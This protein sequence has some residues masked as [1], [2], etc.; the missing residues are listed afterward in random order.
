[1]KIKVIS[2]FTVLLFLFTCFNVLALEKNNSVSFQTL[3]CDD[4]F[5]FSQASF[6]KTDDFTK[7]S[8][9]EAITYTMDTGKPMLPVVIKTYVFPKGTKI[10][11][12]ECTFSGFSEQKI[13]EKI[14]PAPKKIPLIELNN[15][16]LQQDSQPVLDSSIYQSSDF[17][18]SK[19]YDYSITC[20]ING[21]TL[22]I[23]MYPVKVNSL[24]NILQTYESADIN[25]VYEKPLFAPTYDEEYDMVIIA[26][27]Y[28]VET[29]G[30]LITHKNSIGVKT[31]IKTTEEIYKNYTGVDKPEQIKYFIKDAIE[32]NNIKYVLL[33]GGRINQRLKW[34]VPVRYA[35]VP[36]NFEY[37]FISDLYYADM[38]RYNTTS[39]LTEFDDWDSDMDGLY[40]EYITNGSDIDLVPDVYVGRLACRD[41][42]E[43]GI[44][45]KKIIDYENN[46][47]GSDWFKKIILVGGD[48]FPVI[49]S[50]W[51]DYGSYEGENSTDYAS[52]P[53]KNL[54]FDIVELW[55]STNNLKDSSDVI[56]AFGQGAGFIY[57]DGHGNPSQ[58]ATH[59]PNSESWII[60]LDA[61]EM[62]FLSNSDKY[63]VCIIGGC[64]NSQFD[65]ARGNFIKGLLTE[66]LK[67]FVGL[68]DS[69]KIDCDQGSFWKGEWVTDCWS[70]SL[71]KQ[72]NGGSIATIGNTG[73]GY[74]YI[75]S[76]N[77]N[78]LSSWL[79]SRFFYVYSD[80]V[81]Q[82]N[83][84]VGQ[85]YSQSVTDYIHTFRNPPN[86]ENM[87]W[88]YQTQKTLIGY[89]L[90]GDPSLKIGG[91]S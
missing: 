82:G 43:L 90:L 14:M 30:P 79:T 18:P 47:Y 89:A 1:M 56:D 36:D 6:E 53:M 63:P 45:V 76:D 41:K 91:Y 80:F 57:F 5:V 68:F 58:Y 61:K 48:S 22:A 87:D 27:E 86:P 65:V 60:G 34:H 84:T 50:S 21:L 54:G 78:G 3:S 64:H 37:E 71:V 46:T 16:N 85:I 19:N 83:D 25:V 32:K 7:L 24:E 15:N 26:P 31:F 35:S 38:Y 10:K 23:R 9:A 33:A 28:F 4:S 13:S 59:P 29:L 49:N 42:E 52:I 73:I 62:K 55:A 12:V 2:L 67:Y 75:G 8:L 72:E 69:D 51:D 70:W 66:R 11:N 17:Y 88:D 40:G 44:V 74:C 39:N 77:L 20:G 81:S